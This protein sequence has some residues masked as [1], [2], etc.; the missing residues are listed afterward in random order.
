MQRKKVVRAFRI[1]DMLSTSSPSGNGYWLQA[2]HIPRDRVWVSG[3]WFNDHHPNYD[4]YFVEYEGGVY[5][6]EEKFA[7]ESR[8]RFSFWRCCWV[9]RGSFGPV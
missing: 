7:W 5:T 1:S 6:I 9:R 8:M 4:Q 3:D 2:Y